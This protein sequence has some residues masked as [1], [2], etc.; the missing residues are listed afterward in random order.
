MSGYS[1][2][3]FDDVHRFLDATQEFRATEP[4]LTNVIGTIA[5]GIVAGGVYDTSVLLGLRDDAGRI[6]GCAAR[7]SPWNLVVS[8]MPLDAA[9]A[10]GRHVAR[11]DPEL[12]GVSGE[13]T[14]VDAIVAALEP[15]QPPRLAMVDVV[16]VLHTFVP[17]PVPAP[18]APRRATEADRELLLAWMIRF[19]LDAALPLHDAN[20]AVDGRLR[21][22]ALWFWEV[23]GQPVAMAGHAAPV[24]TPAGTVGRIG[25]VYTPAEHRGHGYGA[26]ITSQIVEV[27]MPDCAVI[28]LYADATNPTSNA[29]YARLGFDAAA[30]IIEVDLTVRAN[31]FDN[32]CH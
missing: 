29:V 32:H 8:P 11:I 6:V 3:E 9:S 12:P 16:R 17:P 1:V 26:A 7:T 23:D 21:S 19:A 22:R 30:E 5:A 20:A 31:D 15:E 18:G 2:V 27:L 10:L 13:R 14:A 4:V 28:M 25:P 24:S